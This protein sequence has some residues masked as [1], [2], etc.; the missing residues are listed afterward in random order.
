[1]RVLLIAIAFVLLGCIAAGIGAFY[2]FKK[3]GAHLAAATRVIMN[4]GSQFG[5]SHTDNQ[6][7]IEAISRGHR[8]ASF[9][10]QLKSR[11]FAQSCLAA[12]TPTAELCASSPAPSEIFKAAEWSARECQRRGFAGDQVC[13][14]VMQSVPEHCHPSARRKEER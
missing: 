5:N 7:I 6:C 11:I 3:H 14:G 12:A 10:G 4:E 1:M 13:A 8:D 2:W 9:R